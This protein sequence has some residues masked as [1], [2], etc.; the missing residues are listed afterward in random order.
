[1]KVYWL[2]AGLG[3]AVTVGGGIIYGMSDHTYGLILILGGMVVAI[4]ALVMRLIESAMA[5]SKPKS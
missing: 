3:V 1:M 5:N 2:T 4:M